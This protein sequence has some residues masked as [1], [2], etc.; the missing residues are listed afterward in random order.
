MSAT[1]REDSC[2]HTSATLHN[3][4]FQCTVNSNGNPSFRF[5]GRFTVN[6]GAKTRP[7]LEGAAGL[8]RQL[9][10]MAKGGRPQPVT[11]HPSNTTP[12]L[13]DKGGGKVS[14]TVKNVQ[15]FP[16]TLETWKLR[17]IL[18]RAPEIIA[19]FSCTLGIEPQAARPSPITTTPDERSE[20]LGATTP[21]PPHPT[22]KRPR[23]EDAEH[24]DPGYPDIGESFVFRGKPYRVSAIKTGV[25]YPVIATL[26]PHIVQESSVARVAQG[27][28]GPYKFSLANVLNGN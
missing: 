9:D 23:D 1:V 25:K 8:L 6:L 17:A 10:I 27:D 15:S 20:P 2:L 22:P 4:P 24:D 7:V 28:E 16:A 3:A 13:K 11:A 19:Q 26:L 18:E 5:G 14:L 12:V 21:P